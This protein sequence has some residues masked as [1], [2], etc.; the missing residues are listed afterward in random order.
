VKEK[1]AFIDSDV[2]NIVMY[3]EKEDGS[4]GGLK[5]GA[6]MVNTQIDEYRNRRQKLI[7]ASRRRMQNGE[8][9]PVGF[10]IEI[11]GMTL[12][13]VAARVSV[14]RARV[15]KHMTA[16][17]FETMTI[18]LARAYAEVFGVQLDELLN[19]GVNEHTIASM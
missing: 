10:F 8:I 9:S 7:D 2:Q 13:D 18:G 17:G 6:Y 5:T 12:A 3:V 14:T 1:D 11:G 19:A 4:Y 16:A 15:R